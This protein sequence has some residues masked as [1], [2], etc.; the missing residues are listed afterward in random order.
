M[1]IGFSPETRGVLRLHSE[2]YGF[3]VFGCPL[4]FFPSRGKCKLLV[5]A[6]IHGEE[7]ESTFLLSRSLRAFDRNFESAAFVLCANPDGLM[8]GTRGNAHGVDLNRNFPT[9]NWS[10]EPVGSRSV[11]EASRDTILSPGS[12]CGSEPETV[13][14]VKLIERLS[15]EAIL[16]MHAPIGCI[17][18]LQRTELVRRLQEAFSLPWL[19]DVGYPTPG[20]LG[21]WCKERRL[22]CVTLELPRLAPELLFD[23]YG[24]SFARFLSAYQ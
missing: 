8:L 10:A 3:G 18:A 1:S 14:L 23:R 5:L 9:A 15:P 24:E 21:T 19:P 22:E 11:L 2:T 13:A 16:S 7:P 20:S 6:A 12:R 4:M 17:D